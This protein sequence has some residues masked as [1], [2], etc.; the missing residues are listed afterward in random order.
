MKRSLAVLAVLLVMLFS[1]AKASRQ[2]TAPQVPQHPMS[3]MT[4]NHNAVVK[5]R[6]H[7]RKSTATKHSRLRV[8]DPETIYKRDV[9]FVVKVRIFRKITIPVTHQVKYSDMHSWGSGSI[10]RCKKYGY[11]V[12]TAFHVVSDSSMTFFAETN[13]GAPD[14]LLEVVYGTTT[15]DNAVLRFADPHYVPKHVAVL[16]SSAALVPG[17]PIYAI[18]SPVYSDFHFSVGRLYTK[19]GDPGPFA[20]WLYNGKVMF[21]NTVIFHGYS[22]GPLLNKYGQVVGIA[23]GY[24]KDPEEPSAMYVGVPID[25]IKKI[26]KILK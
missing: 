19:V 22:G 9:R 4:D 7:H 25:E 10:V 12:L 16:G 3:A 8:L 13:D 1:Y 15:Y 23:D 24:Y 18:G 14:Q 2:V 5:A 17:D 6:P 11:C 26:Q 20:P 21:I